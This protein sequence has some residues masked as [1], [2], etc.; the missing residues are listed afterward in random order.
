[1]ALWPKVSDSKEESLSQEW[2]D[3]F[4]VKRAVSKAL[5]SLRQAK[6]IGSSLEGEVDL[7]AGND[8][9]KAVL[10][11]NLENLRYYFL[12]SKVELKDGE[13]PSGALDAE[14]AGLKLKSVVRKSS[15]QKCARCW[16]YYSPAEMD[17][18]HTD[19]CHRCGPVVQKF[20][21]AGTWSPT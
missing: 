15:G 14:D 6:T 1:L 10:K 12:V 13:A 19:I 7:F 8:R 11:K 2:N 20:Q 5:E 18:T 9:M 17:K 3:I 4:A 16:N 21:A